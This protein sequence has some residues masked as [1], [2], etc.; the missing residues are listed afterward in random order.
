MFRPILTMAA[1][2][3]MTASVGMAA[4]GAPQVRGARTPALTSQDYIEIQQLSARYAFDIDTCVNAGAD[5]ADLF[6][7]D[8]EF[9]VSQQWGVAGNRKTKGRVALMDAA[10]GDGQGGCKDPKTTMG[11]GI[12]HIVVNH[13]ITPTPDGATGRSYMLA[14]GVGGDP[15]RIERQGGYDDVYVKTPAGWRIKS[16]IHVFPNMSESVQFGGRGRRGQAGGGPSQPGAS[17][18]PAP[19][20]PPQPPGR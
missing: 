17:P 7:D 4:S 15:T 16:R 12:S 3:G 13:V 18:A 1:A 2:V 5:F 6:T 11:Y 10:G 9:S 20:A 8:G 19:S 14:I